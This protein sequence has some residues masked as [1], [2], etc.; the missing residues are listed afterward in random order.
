MTTITPFHDGVTDLPTLY[1]KIHDCKQV[2]LIT[3]NCA[4]GSNIYIVVY[5]DT[6]ENRALVYHNKKY[7]YVDTIHS[8]ISI[9]NII[10][11][12]GLSYL[13]ITGIKQFVDDKPV[14]PNDT[15]LDMPILESRMSLIELTPNIHN[16]YD[17]CDNVYDNLCGDGIDS[18]DYDSD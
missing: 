7:V 2:S 4:D 14:T 12:F 1:N 17:V 15:M 9:H 8:P 11:A 13:D 18:D 5:W 16:M 3:G 6:V 10:Q